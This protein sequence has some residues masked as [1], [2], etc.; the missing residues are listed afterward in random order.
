MVRYVTTIVFYEKEVI[1]ECHEHGTP[2]NTIILPTLNLI[3]DKLTSLSC[4]EKTTIT[5]LRERPLV[6]TMQD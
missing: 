6:I 2:L 3:G 4:C 1:V 5:H